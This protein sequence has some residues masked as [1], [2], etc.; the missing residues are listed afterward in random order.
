MILLHYS[1]FWINHAPSLLHSHRQSRIAYSWLRRPTSQVLQALTGIKWL[2][3]D[4]MHAK[5]VQESLAQKRKKSLN[6]TRNSWG[7]HVYLQCCGLG[8]SLLGRFKQP[9]GMPQ[10][11]SLAGVTAASKNLSFHLSFFLSSE[12][13]R[14]LTCCFPE[15]VLRHESD[16]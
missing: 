12:P 15:G 4:S 6:F 14:F 13:Y 7:Y 3:T 8:I 11:L 10:T 16:E 9:P 2:V 1:L 5:C